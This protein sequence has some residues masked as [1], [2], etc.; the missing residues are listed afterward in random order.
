LIKRR[1]AELEKAATRQNEVSWK[2]IGAV[3]RVA[4]IIESGQVRNRAGEHS[5]ADLAERARDDPDY[6]RE[7]KTRIDDVLAELPRTGRT[8]EYPRFFFA[9]RLTEVAC[10]ATG[11][12]PAY[13]DAIGASENPV[14]E[15]LRAGLAI[16]GLDGERSLDETLRK[17]NSA[18][19]RPKKKDGH[20]YKRTGLM[21]DHEF[22]PILGGDLHASKYPIREGFEKTAAAFRRGADGYFAGEGFGSEDYVGRLFGEAL[23]G[24]EPPTC[25][26]DAYQHILFEADDWFE[27]PLHISLRIASGET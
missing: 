27:R 25:G 24:Y 5:I 17:F 6:I 13:S 9:W 8:P 4:S 20:Y 3:A 12:A 14:K 18:M 21:D 16:V 15:I 19:A 10:A 11:I 23:V 1:S 22:V 26:R 7:L 2:L